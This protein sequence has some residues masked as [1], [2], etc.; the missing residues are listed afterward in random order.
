MRQQVDRIDCNT[1]TLGNCETVRFWTRLSQ[2][3]HTGIPHNSESL[4]CFPFL[5]ETSQ[6]YK[7]KETAD[8]HSI[9]QTEAISPDAQLKGDLHRCDC[10]V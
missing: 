9:A 5:A 2:E 6:M 3:T 7:K 8:F 10:V 1:D 4:L